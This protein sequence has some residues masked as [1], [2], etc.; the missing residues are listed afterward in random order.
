MAL[1]QYNFKSQSVGRNVNVTVV[2]PTDGLSFYDPSEAEQY[3]HNPI[4]KVIPHTYQPGMKFQTVYVYHGGGEDN[5]VSYRYA[6]LERAAQ[7]NKVMLVC[8]DI[9]FFGTDCAGRNYFTYLTQEL[10]CVIQTMFPSSPKRE[11]N[12]VMGYAMGA[13][14]ALGVSVIRPDLFAACLDISGGIGMTLQTSTMVEELAGDHFRTFMP[15]Y[16]V[17]FGEPENFPGSRYDLYPIARRNKEEGQTLTHVTVV[18]GSEEFI[19]KRVE[20][21]VARLRELEYPMDYLCLEGY[22]HNWRTWDEYL[23]RGLEEIFPLKKEYLYQ[24][25]T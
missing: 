15:S 25:E 18:C 3:G 6:A 9:Q 5:S 7:E 13:N 20:D 2:L 22:D 17:A 21:D 23:V 24:E 1:I 11:D 10:P 12:F 4:T 16:H 8:P 14:V 19:R